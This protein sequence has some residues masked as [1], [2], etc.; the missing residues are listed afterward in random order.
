MKKYIILLLLVF[1]IILFTITA[2]AQKIILDIVN[3]NEANL[4]FIDKN[5]NVIPIE[6]N[7]FTIYALTDKYNDIVALTTSNIIT[8]ENINLGYSLSALYSN[9]KTLE[10]L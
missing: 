5:G 6:L 4:K 3:K 1:I 10:Q 2:N 9:E 8:L 7:A